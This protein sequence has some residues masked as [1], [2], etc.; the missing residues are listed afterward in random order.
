MTNRETLRSLADAVEALSGPCRET[1]AL[2]AELAYG[3]KL[4]PVPPDAKGENTGEV[5]TPD[6]QPFR[7]SDGRPWNYPPLGKVHRAYHCAEYTRD[8]RD[9]DLPINTIRTNTAIALRALAS[10][11]A[12]GE[13]L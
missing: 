7:Q 6:G 9:W 5:L 11:R 1:D 10:L 3:W 12:I 4:A 8:C 13:G 2:I